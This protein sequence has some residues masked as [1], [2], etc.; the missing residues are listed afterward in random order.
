MDKKTIL[1]R[2][3]LYLPWSI[4]FNVIPIKIPVSHFVDFAK[5]MLKFI[6][7]GRRKIANIVLKKNKVRGLTLPDF[8][9]FYKATLRKMVWYQQKKK[10]R[11]ME[12]NRWL[13]LWQ[14]LLRYIKDSWK[15][16]LISWA[17]LKLKTST[18]KNKM[19]R[20]WEDKSQSKRKYCKRYLIKDW[21]LKCTKTSFFLYMCHI[22]H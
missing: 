4:R 16:A 12:Q 3:Q 10:N 11:S 22:F 17:S 5:L 2:H 9:I 8:K 20:E 7:K 15:K 21:Y 18:L 1:S 14:W 13:W 6:R 19:S